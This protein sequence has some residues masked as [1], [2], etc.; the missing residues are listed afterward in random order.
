MKFASVAP[1]TSSRG[2]TRKKFLKPCSVRSVRVAEGEI[3][4]RL[5][6]PSTGATASTSWLPAGPTI[7]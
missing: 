3:I 1:C 4:G 2:T 6:L 5:T 7:T